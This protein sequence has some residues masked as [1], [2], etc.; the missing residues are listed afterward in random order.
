MKH[1]TREITSLLSHIVLM[2]ENCDDKTSAR[3]MNVAVQPIPSYL[4]STSPVP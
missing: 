4:T 3:R 1:E 2:N